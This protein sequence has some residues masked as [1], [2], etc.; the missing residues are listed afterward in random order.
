MPSSAAALSRA[1]CSTTSGKEKPAESEERA[2]EL[3][4]RPRQQ[5]AIWL[6]SERLT[7]VLVV[8]VWGARVRA[9]HQAV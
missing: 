7:A 4:A 8:L 3:S 6:K 9:L 2:S 1:L 5:A